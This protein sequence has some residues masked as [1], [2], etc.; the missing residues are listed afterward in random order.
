MAIS[1]DEGLFTRQG[2]GR[3]APPPWPSFPEQVHHTLVEETPSEDSR[4]SLLG[5]AH[6]ERSDLV[7]EEAIYMILEAS[8]LERQS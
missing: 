2:A 4:I 6:T 1:Q 5:L 7:W 8:L 3:K